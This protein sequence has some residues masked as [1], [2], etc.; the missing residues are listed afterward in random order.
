MGPKEKQKLKSKNFTGTLY[1]NLIK[2]LQ[3]TT[4][5]FLGQHCI[6]I[7]KSPMV[8]GVNLSSPVDA[9]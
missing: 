8:S 3:R 9:S 5:T 7:A 2:Q 1:L 6:G 4:Q